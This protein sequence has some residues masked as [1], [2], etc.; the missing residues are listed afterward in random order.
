MKVG[1]KVTII[2]SKLP[3]YLNEYFILFNIND[4]KLFALGENK[5]QGIAN[6]YAGESQLMLVKN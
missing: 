1:D 3:N 4:D 6:C 2:D 5:D